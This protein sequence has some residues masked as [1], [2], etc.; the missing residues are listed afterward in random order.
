MRRKLLKQRKKLRQ[1]SPSEN[2]RMDHF[3]KKHWNYQIRI[4]KMRLSPDRRIFDLMGQKCADT[5][6]TSKIGIDYSKYRLYYSFGLE[7]FLTGI[8]IRIYQEGFIGTRAKDLP[9][10]NV[11]LIFKRLFYTRK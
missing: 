1:R 9:Y 11:L 6:E 7:L 10:A 4:P 3:Q 5:Y 8:F 2:D